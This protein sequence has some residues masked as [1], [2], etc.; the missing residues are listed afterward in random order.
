MHQG[1]R[2]PPALHGGPGPLAVH[3][4]PAQALEGAQGRSA[5]D[6]ASAVLR[7]LQVQLP[8]HGGPDRLQGP[9]RGPDQGLLREFHTPELPGD[10]GQRQVRPRALRVLLSDRQLAHQAPRQVR[11]RVQTDPLHPHRPL[12]P[13]RRDQGG[14]LSLHRRNRTAVR[15][16][17]GKRHQGNEATRVSGP[18]DLRR[19]HVRPASAQSLREKTQTGLTP[20]LP[21]VHTQVPQRDFPRTG[22]LDLHLAALLVKPPAC[23]HHFHGGLHHT[24]PREVPDVHVHCTHDQQLPRNTQEPRISHKTCW[25]VRGHQQLHAAGTRCNQGKVWIL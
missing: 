14:L 13:G 8:D 7:G 23:P 16:R 11:P 12:R 20:L 21:T 6:S 17:K 9:Q 18:L 1:N 22:R 4:P 3:L 10:P 5:G 19:T 15:G 2:A 24:T 25:E